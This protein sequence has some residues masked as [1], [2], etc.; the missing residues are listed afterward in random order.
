[1]DPV[2][3]MRWGAGVGVRYYTAIGPVRL[4]D[5]KLGAVR[6]LTREELGALLDLVK[7]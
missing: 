4:G 6:D 3:R 5:L 2:S 7:L 1:M